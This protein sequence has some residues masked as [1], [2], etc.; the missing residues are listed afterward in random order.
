MGRRLDAWVPLIHFQGHEI[1]RAGE[2]RNV[3]SGNILKTSVNQAG[4]R[5]VAI[6]NTTLGKYQ[7]VAVGQLVAE[8][9]CGPSTPDAET[10]L[11][12]D[13]NRDNNSAINVMWS[14]RWHA[15]AFH[16]EIKKD[17]RRDRGPQIVDENGRVYKNVM[18]A[19][20]HTG[21]L[22]SAIDHA[23]RYNS[24][25]DDN[26]HVNFVQRVWPGGRIFRLA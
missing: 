17:D 10:V 12:L 2:I 1:N 3:H 16:D 24:A 11:Y 20:R 26:E 4:V 21:C 7:N 18:D 8:A 15:M 25:L 23:V 14:P 5:Y 22:P 19:A 13:G 9:F 6:R